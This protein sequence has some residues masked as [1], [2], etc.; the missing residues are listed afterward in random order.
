MP[1][2]PDRGG[3]DDSC[4]ASA[5][6]PGS[7]TLAAIERAADDCRPREAYGRAALRLSSRVERELKVDEWPGAFH[8]ETVDVV[9]TQRQSTGLEYR[10]EG[11]GR[12][13]DVLLGLDDDGT[14]WHC[15]I[16]VNGNSMTARGAQPVVAFRRAGEL[17]RELM[18]RTDGIAPIDEMEELLD[19]AEAFYTERAEVFPPAMAGALGIHARHPAPLE[20]KEI[21]HALRAADFVRRVWGISS[22]YWRVLQASWVDAGR[23]ISIVIKLG[24]SASP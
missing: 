24:R 13:V 12:R 10:L 4:T 22:R 15:V 5:P 21:E 7:G 11:E 8:H 9:R 20:P 19:H 2:T 6:P 17:F 1:G 14:N 3:G 18:I 16:A 23:N